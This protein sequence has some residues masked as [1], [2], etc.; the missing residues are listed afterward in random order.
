M[1]YIG[2]LCYDFYIFWLW[3]GLWKMRRVS[4]YRYIDKKDV[5]I[6]KYDWLWFMNKYYCLVIDLKF[7][8]L[9]C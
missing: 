4:V 6:G 5:L 8:V 1:Y 2:C 7:E 9:I 3:V